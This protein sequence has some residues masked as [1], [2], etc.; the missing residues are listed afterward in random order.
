MLEISEWVYSLLN[1]STILSI[2]TDG[3]FPIAANQESVNFVNYS[4]GSLDVLTK[5]NS[6]QLTVKVDCFADNYNNALRL[7]DKVHEVMRSVNAAIVDFDTEYLQED[8]RCV[9]FSVYNIKHKF[10]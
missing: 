4:F 5:D 7:H 6:C 2:A 1:T 8:D 3:V 10:K 9:S